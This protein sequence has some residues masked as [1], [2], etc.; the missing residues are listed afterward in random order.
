[1]TTGRIASLGLLLAGILAAGARAQDTASPSVPKPVPG[2]SA[3]GP[4]MLENTLYF[5]PAG[6]AAM[7]VSVFAPYDLVSLQM[8]YERRI[9][10]HLSGIGTVSYQNIGASVDGSEVEIR[11][12]DVLAGVRW[13]PLNDFSGFYLQPALNLDLAKAIGSNVNK[14]GTVEQNRFG[15]MLYLGTNRRW[16]ALSLDWNAG[17]GYL[18]WDDSYS[19]FK[20]ST[21]V[22][23]EKKITEVSSLTK[24]Y[25]GFLAGTPQFGMNLALGLGF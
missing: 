7:I 23:T 24:S 8:D 25:A 17:I 13:Y 3:S 10:P 18:P 1:M 12:F 6:I 16:G 22:T 11:Y 14:R 19:E 5:H 2:V 9:V 20:R 21:E 4:D 15:A